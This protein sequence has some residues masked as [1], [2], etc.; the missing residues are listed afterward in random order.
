MS[1]DASV[2]SV[3]HG[4]CSSSGSPEGRPEMRLYAA[5]RGSRPLIGVARSV[6]FDAAVQQ[7]AEPVVIEIAEVVPDTF[8]LL[9]QQ[10][11][12]LGRAVGAPPVSK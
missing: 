8:D 1:A 3:T 9:D 6:P 4:M 7:R 5:K 10:V 12:G 11:D 2:S